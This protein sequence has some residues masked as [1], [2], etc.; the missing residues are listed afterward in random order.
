MDASKTQIDASKTDMEQ[1]IKTS[2]EL[3]NQV[4]GKVSGLDANVTKIS[5]LANIKSV[6]RPSPGV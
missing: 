3:N 4:L 5:N 6:Q 1:K 2:N